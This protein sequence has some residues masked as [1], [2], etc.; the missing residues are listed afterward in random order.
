[1]Q[2]LRNVYE[3][4]YD[5][6]VQTANIHPYIFPKHLHENL[7]MLTNA[8]GQL[9]IVRFLANVPDILCTSLRIQSFG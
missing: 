7:A 6:I 1:M 8:D 9:T 3:C 2:L 5:Q 4:S